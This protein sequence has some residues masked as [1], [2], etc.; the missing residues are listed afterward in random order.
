MPL[1][2]KTKNHVLTIRILILLLGFIYPLS[3]RAQSDC[4]KTLQEAR[5]QYDQGMID[6]IPKMLAP[7]MQ[8]GF[9]RAQ[10]IEA[11]KL[12]ILAYLFNDDQ[13]EAEK[14]MTEFLKRYP[15]Y[16]I[17]P[18]D[19]VEFIH[20]FE[21]YRTTSEFSIGLMAGFNLTNPRIIEHY[22]LLDGFGTDPSNTTGTGYQL[23]LGVGRY[24]GKRLMIN[25]ELQW[26][27]H[28]YTFYEEN[29]VIPRNIMT[30]E[31]S[32]Y[33]ESFKFKEQ[34]NKATLPVTALFEINNRKFLW[35]VRAGGSVNYILSASGTPSADQEGQPVPGKTINITDYLN[36]YYFCAILGAGFHFKIP[37]GFL[38]L[39]LR[40]NM[41]I[42]NLLRTDL[43]YDDTYS[44]SFFECLGDDFSLN[45]FTFSVGY[46]FSFYSPKKQ[47]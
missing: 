13:F 25:I 7:C 4:S 21:T 24:L 1:F 39:D 47:K 36:T 17:M 16:E 46:Y 33:T 9:S 6:E 11:Y 8:E 15:E 22:S 38:A 29:T 20:L 26:V 28:G 34:L 32:K 19:P 10:R 23:G 37:R 41:G 44:T 40:Y 3:S 18:N 43:R 42:N 5:N 35:F 30:D 27:H 14:T 45:T 31:E 12:L 2:L